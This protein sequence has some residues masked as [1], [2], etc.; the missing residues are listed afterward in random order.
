MSLIEMT[1]YNNIIILSIIYVFMSFIVQL[2]WSLITT[3]VP[4]FPF[5]LSFSFIFIARTT[6]CSCFTNLFLLHHH[7]SLISLSL[8]FDNCNLI[9][10]WWWRLEKTFLRMLPLGIDIPSLLIHYVKSY[11]I[12]PYVLLIF[13]LAFL[14]KNLIN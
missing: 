2:F 5:G 13:K 14:K 1:L 6:T 12:Q 4:F 7:Y 10:W 11:F 3:L 9:K 8:Q